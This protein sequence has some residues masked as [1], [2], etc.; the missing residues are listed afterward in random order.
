MY[1]IR[2]SSFQTQEPAV[3]LNPHAEAWGF[4]AHY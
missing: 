1:N 3:R 4:D 2:Q